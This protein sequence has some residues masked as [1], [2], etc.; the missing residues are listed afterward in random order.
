[1]ESTTRLRRASRSRVSTGTAPHIS[2]R[3]DE[4]VGF[5][6]RRLVSVL[7]TDLVGFTSLAEHRDAEEVRELLTRYFDAAR[8]LVERYGW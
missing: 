7:F 6:E 4:G 2:S 3:L 8:R 5:A 1:M